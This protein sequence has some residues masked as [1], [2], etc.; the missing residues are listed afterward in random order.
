MRIKA[1][2]RLKKTS[3]AASQLDP[4]EPPA[5]V[6]ALSGVP[7]AGRDRAH[8]RPEKIR[9]RG[10]RPPAAARSREGEE[11]ERV[12]AKEAAA[13]VGVEPGG[14]EGGHR[15]LGAEAEGIVAAEHD[16]LAAERLQHERERAR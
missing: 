11:G 3:G 7:E 6:A 15:V 8:E 4:L 1:S 14:L 16:A 9:A 2:G 10:I 5:D 13:Q 12:V